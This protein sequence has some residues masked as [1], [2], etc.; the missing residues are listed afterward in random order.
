MEPL[1]APP[2]GLAKPLTLFAPCRR[3]L[4]PHLI[5]PAGAAARDRVLYLGCGCPG[6]EPGR[7]P[8]Q[9]VHVSALWTGWVGRHHKCFLPRKGSRMTPCAPAHR[10][11]QCSPHLRWSAG[12]TRCRPPWCSA[13]ATPACVAVPRRRKLPLSACLWAP[14][15]RSLR[16]GM[17]PAPASQWRQ[18]RRGGTSDSPEAAT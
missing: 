1:L 14:S 5:G 2:P 4:L 6:L 11:R 13:C 12:Q 16:T 15:R 10:W 17:P 3:A 8:P 7:A 9:V 18:Q